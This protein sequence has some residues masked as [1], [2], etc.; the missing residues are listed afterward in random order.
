VAKAPAPL[1]SRISARAEVVLGAG[2]DREQF[3]L[4]ALGPLEALGGADD[5][6][7]QQALQRPL[8]RQLLDQRLLQ[9]ERGGT[10]ARRRQ[11]TRS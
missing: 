3:T 4:D 1:R 7:R 8:G 11:S 2:L 10:L 9:R 6:H 5:A